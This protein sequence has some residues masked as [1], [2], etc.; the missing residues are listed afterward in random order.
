MKK[1][2]YTWLIGTGILFG[3]A[4]VIT[5]LLP[6]AAYGLGQLVAVVWVCWSLICIFVKDKNG[7]EHE[8]ENNI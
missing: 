7:K 2:W 6:Y 8:K 3:V 4:M 5:L 1:A